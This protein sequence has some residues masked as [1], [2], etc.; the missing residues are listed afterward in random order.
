MS[1]LFQNKRNLFGIILG[2]V[3]FSLTII[4]LMYAYYS[5]KSKVL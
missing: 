2:I 1:N 3:M 5:W 4:S